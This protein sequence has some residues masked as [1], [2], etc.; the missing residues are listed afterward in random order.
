MWHERAKSHNLYFTHTVWEMLRE[1][2]RRAGESP[3]KI[4]RALVEREYKEKV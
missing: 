3:S 2:A 1:L 4:V